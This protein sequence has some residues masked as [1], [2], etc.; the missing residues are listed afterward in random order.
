[1]RRSLKFYFFICLFM[2]V[3]VFPVKANAMQLFVQTLTG[4]HITIE[5]E[6]TDKIESIKEKIEDKEWVATN[7]QKLI[8][9]GKVLEDGKTLQDYSIQKD[10]TLH[11]TLLPFSMGGQEV[12]IVQHGDGLYI[13]GYEKDKFTYRG[14]NPN[15]YIL[16]NNEMWRIISVQD[17]SLKIVKEDLLSL[18]KPFNEAL[19]QNWDNSSLKAYVNGEY[20]DNLN[21][22][23]KKYIE[24]NTWNMGDISLNNDDLRNQ[25]TSENRR[26]SNN[27]YVG[28]MT[29]SEY[30]RSNTNKGS[31]ETFSL[32]NFN[33]SACQSTNWMF[34]G[35]AFWTLTA[36]DL[37]P[38]MVN[39]VQDDGTINRDN[40]HVLFGVR[41][42]LVLKDN[43][44]LIGQGTKD[45]PFA[46]IDINVLDSLNGSVSYSISN[47]LVLV[48]TQADEGYELDK[49]MVKGTNGNI[50]LSD[51]TFV[52][53][54]D[55]FVTIE[56]AFKEINSFND[57]G[58]SNPETSDNII[59]YVATLIIALV[60]IV[61]AI[62]SIK[63]NKK[64]A[65]ACFFE[66]S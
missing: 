65:E 35:K 18:E 64:Q 60:I 56:A 54:S 2:M 46:I 47:G 43:I 38:Y 9:A 57:E 4:K 28:L 11:L 48:K 66:K 52:L 36:D 25:I 62:I 21:D 30:L 58:V 42:V 14:S 27:S 45:N 26:Q 13:D 10:S 22:N 5:V 44:S 39:F 1:M 15:N 32:N 8:F 7:L 33:F 63:K 53:P 3:L 20:Y 19:D 17:G 29:V 6:P 51:N 23:V 37:K 16:F 24:N 59:I 12:S 61:L 55:G 49:I 31:C 50:S 41:P 40:S 34:N